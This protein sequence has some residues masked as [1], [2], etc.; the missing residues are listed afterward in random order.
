MAVVSPA[1]SSIS[2]WER[3][4]PDKV[5]H[6]ANLPSGSHTLYLKKQAGFGAK[7]LVTYK[8]TIDIEKAWYETYLAW[9]GAAA[10]MLILILAAIRFQNRRLIKKNQVLEEAISKRTRSLN[11][12]MEALQDSEEQLFKQVKIQQRMIASIT[13][14][15]KTPLKAV[16]SVSTEIDKLLNEGKLDQ[17]RAFSSAVT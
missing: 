3:L 13:H 4:T 14:D 1:P 6:F 12:T 7:S 10:V 5:I 17:V 11:E 8:F 15:V 16:S 9:A 2:D